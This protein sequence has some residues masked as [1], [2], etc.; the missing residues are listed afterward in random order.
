[1][2]AHA[3]A[4]EHEDDPTS[5]WEVSVSDSHCGAGCVLG[6]ICGEWI[7]WATG[8]TIGSITRGDR[9]RPAASGA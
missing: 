1:M 6:D 5:R 3:A 4:P 8:W 7:V 2:H 9:C